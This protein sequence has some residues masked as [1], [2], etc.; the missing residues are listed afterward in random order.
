MAFV[1]NNDEEEKNPQMQ[2]AGTLNPALNQAPQ[3]AS[4]VGGS[5]AGNA[6]KAQA[7]SPQ[8]TASQTSTTK[9]PSYQDLGAYI[10]ANEP[11]VPA[12]ANTIAA[13]INQQAVDIG[14]NLAT[15]GQQFRQGVNDQNIGLNLSPI[16]QAAQNPVE[17]ASN[18]QNVAAFQ[19][20][21]N[22][23]YNGPQTFEGSDVYSSLNN[24]IQNAVNKAGDIYAPG[25]IRQL[26]SSQETNP[27]PGETNLDELLLQ[28]N[29]E[30]I[31]TIGAA[32]GSVKSLPAGL[33]S[34]AQSINPDIARAISNDQAAQNAIQSAFNG[35][36]GVIPTFKN[37]IN[38]ELTRANQADQA[39][40]AQYNDLVGAL[41]G[42]NLLSLSPEQQAELGIQNNA[43]S[44]QQ[45]ENAINAAFNN[46]PTF[47]SLLTPGGATEPATAAN[48]AEPADYQEAQAL[49]TL[50]GN[51]IDLPINPAD[52]DQAGTYFN[53]IQSPSLP[54]L[55]VEKS[56]ANTVAQDLS[57]TLQQ[58]YSTYNPSDLST[59]LPLISEL[60]ALSKTQGPDFGG[61]LSPQQ[62]AAFDAI[63]GGPGFQDLYSYLNSQRS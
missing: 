27:T 33:A 7:G 43:S 11:Q 25:G 24:D 28:Q 20:I 51:N 8:G 54:A 39:N 63:N 29:P 38:D 47:S 17:F 23:A 58:H 30:A 18:P 37:S 31:S 12:M 61:Y 45:A 36:T 60:E 49:Q 35:P 56:L 19:K 34:Q 4:G 2:A 44:W 55:N 40:T 5:T 62:Q 9:A 13:P 10:R 53:S 52:A 6:G 14:N 21:N 50:L 42:N 48:V 26:V 15:Q 46:A 57:P 1:Q 41:Q 16:S 3:T 59:A 32:Q 22:A